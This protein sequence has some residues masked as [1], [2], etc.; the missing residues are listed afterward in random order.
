MERSSQSA[1]P[2]PASYK[3]LLRQISPSGQETDVKELTVILPSVADSNASEG[4]KVK[5][6]KPTNGCVVM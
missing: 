2:N 1:D 5:R 6:G 4:T 3:V